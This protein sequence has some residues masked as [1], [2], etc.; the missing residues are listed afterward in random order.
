MSNYSD[1]YEAVIGLEVH[2]QLLTK[3]KLFC[4]DSA[5][6]GSGPNTHISPITLAHPG[7]L[8]KLNKEAIELYKEVREKFPDQR[9]FADEADKFLAKL[10][11]Y[12]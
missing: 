6:F 5:G 8:P 2:A 10:G 12:N 3:S 11:V 1:K 9:S 7:T 4:G